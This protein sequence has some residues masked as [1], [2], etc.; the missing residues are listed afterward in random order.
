MAKERE[1]LGNPPDDVPEA[2]EQRRRRLD[3]RTFIRTGLAVGGGLVAAAYVKPNLQSIGIPRAF[4][5]VTPGPGGRPSIE[6]EPDD[7]DA[8]AGDVSSFE[9]LNVE[10]CNVSGHLVVSISQWDYDVTVLEG[11][12]FLDDTIG[13]DGVLLP[14]IGT[15]TSPPGG[16]GTKEGEC[17][18]FPVTFNLLPLWTSEGTKIKVRI[19]ATG[20]ADDGQHAD[21]RLTLTLTKYSGT[22]SKHRGSKRP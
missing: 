15:L 17:T 7:V 14:T 8:D 1:Q 2:E 12:E 4:A 11:P 20:T 21:A 13:I 9:F 22:H 3:R 5:Q 10:I 16:D 18:D 6:F 19:V